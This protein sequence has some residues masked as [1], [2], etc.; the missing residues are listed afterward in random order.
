MLQLRALLATALAHHVSNFSWLWP[1]DRFKGVLSQEPAAAQR[2][3]VMLAMSHMV[4][5]SDYDTMR[6]VCVCE[7]RGGTQHRGSTCECLT[8][9]PQAG[10]TPGCH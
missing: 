7:G 2:G 3:W 6:K 5:L 4:R 1:W 9:D 8:A 10:V